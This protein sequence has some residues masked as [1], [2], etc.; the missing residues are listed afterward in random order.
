MP[1]A[2]GGSKDE[3][4]REEAAARGDFL[5]EDGEEFEDIEQGVSIRDTKEF[6]EEDEDE[7][8]Q[9][10]ES[11]EDE[12]DDEEVEDEEDSEED[13]ESDE[14]LEDEDSEE[15]TDEEEDQ[16]TEEVDEEE[17]TQ[18]KQPRI[19]KSRL[20]QEINKRKERDDQIAQQQRQI[21]QLMDLLN[22]NYSMQEARNIQQGQQQEEEQQQ[23]PEPPQYDFD[24]AE[25]EYA[26]ALMEGE[27]EKATRIRKEMRDAERAQMK[28]EQEQYRKEAE[29]AA[30]QEISVA[31]DQRRL[32]EYQ[33]HYVNQYKFFDTQSPEYN[34]EA[35]NRVNDLMSKFVK[36]GSNRSEALKEAVD[37]VAPT[38]APA[39][40]KPST[41]K[42]TAKK[43]K[44]QE[45]RSKQ[46]KKN[47]QAANRQ[48]SK[49]KRRQS[50]AR[51]IESEELDP[52]KMT[53]REFDQLSPSQKKRL[54]GD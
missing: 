40:E 8:Q 45:R 43:K 16:D 46:V 23:E 32:E 3:L 13:S 54:R 9:E 48:P 39:E 15:D 19:P 24:K 12:E 41:E 11:D 22:K 36:A 35:V 34:A 26:E 44:T 21:E 53:E 30:K 1:P 17:D 6:P 10:E 52:T 33:Q 29:R 50:K 7:D 47:A 42:K 2:Q 27:T 38:Y 5:D 4:D 28:H 37:L 51:Q 14:E 49:Y 25:A 18:K 31:E 20:D